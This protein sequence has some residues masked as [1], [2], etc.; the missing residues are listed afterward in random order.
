MFS[1]SFTSNSP[2]PR[3]GNSAGEQMPV[4]IQASVVEEHGGVQ[5]HSSQTCTAKDNIKVMMWDDTKVALKRNPYKRDHTE[6][7]QKTA[8]TCDNAL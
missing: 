2:I 3:S 5:C 8:K 1:C 6:L 4:V 7:T